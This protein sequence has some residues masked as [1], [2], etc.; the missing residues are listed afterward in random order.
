[1]SGTADRF[2]AV[3]EPTN[4]WLVW[5]RLRNLPAEHAGLALF[6]LSQPQAV[7]YCRMLNAAEPTQ[8]RMTPPTAPRTPQEAASLTQK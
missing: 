1:M 8:H 3:I 5:D 7:M 4:R 2:E 6:G